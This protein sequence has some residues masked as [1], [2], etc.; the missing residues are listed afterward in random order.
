VEGEGYSQTFVTDK[1]GEI[2]IE[3]LRVGKY[4]VS[5]V[6]TDATKDYKLPDAVEIEIIADETLEVKV[7]NDK[8]TVEYPPKTGDESNVWLWLVL[9]LA[10]GLGLTALLVVPKLRKKTRK[11]ASR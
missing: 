11:A 6:A 1:N 4:T 8:I 9:A 7:H 3:N 2:F 5:E 10:S